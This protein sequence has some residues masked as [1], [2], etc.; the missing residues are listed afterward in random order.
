MSD[1]MSDE[2]KTGL[3]TTPKMTALA[4]AATN[5]HASMES[6]LLHAAW[7]ISRTP[8]KSWLLLMNM[9]SWR[10]GKFTDS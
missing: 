5:E 10:I 1:V 3:T 6:G 9:F 4:L 8:D 2:L 7:L